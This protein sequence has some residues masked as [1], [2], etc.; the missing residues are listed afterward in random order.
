M[1][2]V[3]IASIEQLKKE[4][5]REN[6]DFVDFQIILAGGLAMSSKRISYRPENNEFLIINEID[7]S[8]QE[9]PEHEL[10]KETILLKAISMDCLIKSGT[11]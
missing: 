1:A 10:N 2:E 5:Y 3:Y 6:G 9:V 7:E 4:A 8:F 11:D